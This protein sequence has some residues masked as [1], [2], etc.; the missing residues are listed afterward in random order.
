M[1]DELYVTSHRRSD[2]NRL[3]SNENFI[4][5]SQPERHRYIYRIISLS[6]LFQLFSTR[7]NVFVKPKRWDDPFE[8]F[9]LRSRIRFPSGEL[10]NHG[11][12]DSIYGQ[13]WTLQS[14]SDAMWRIYS[15]HGDAVRIR[16][17]P[18]R[19]AQSIIDSSSV[20]P[21]TV[22]IGKVSYL[23]QAALVRFARLS[24][25]TDESAYDAKGRTLLVKRLA[26]IH[27]REVRALIFAS[28]EET[29]KS[30]SDF[31]QCPVNPHALIDQIMLDPRYSA[32]KAKSV[33]RQIAAQTDFRGEILR[34]L[35]YAPPPRLLLDF[36][37]PKPERPSRSDVH[38]DWVQL[39]PAKKQ[40]KRLKPWK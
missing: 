27:E 33:K 21:H 26:F 24:F 25:K 19:L 39:V 29:A 38:P 15:P 4:D 22:R 34:S 14:A 10:Y 32:E 18:K 37:M 7:V 9:I 31:L 40:S 1:P 17:T 16:S 8:N 11:N 35:L 30:T 5:L 12:R 28:V 3:V 20:R 13:C 6:R 2:L 23:S 36:A